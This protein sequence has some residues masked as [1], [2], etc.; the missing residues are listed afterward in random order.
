MTPS[1]SQVTCVCVTP[2]TNSRPCQ[3]LLLTKPLFPIQDWHQFSL[4]GGLLLASSPFHWLVML[5]FQILIMSSPI[6][7]PMYHQQLQVQLDDLD[8]FTH[9][10]N[11]QKKIRLFSQHCCI[12]RPT[13]PH[14]SIEFTAD[15]PEIY[16]LH[17]WKLTVRT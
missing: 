14:I 12:F 3:C 16:M 2:Q 5:E 15:V 9:H 17:S 7:S 4:V 13:S 10:K 1:E 6:E 8:E 11:I